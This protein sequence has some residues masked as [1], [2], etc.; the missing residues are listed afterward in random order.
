[1]E[2]LENLG[3]NMGKCAHL[4][5]VCGGW[6]DGDRI[7]NMWGLVGG[8]HPPKLQDLR[9]VLDLLGAQWGPGR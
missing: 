2:A 7:R 8:S 3:R 1:M 5:Q 4:A 6:G 9:G